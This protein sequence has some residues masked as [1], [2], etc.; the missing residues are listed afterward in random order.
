M[1]GMKGISAHP[2]NELKRYSKWWKR[3]R[4]QTLELSHKQDDANLVMN[5]MEIAVSAFS[6][7]PSLNITDGNRVYT[8]STP[9]PFETSKPTYRGPESH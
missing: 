4:D 2:G 6:P 5:I 1:G 3:R 7:R 8:I 9:K